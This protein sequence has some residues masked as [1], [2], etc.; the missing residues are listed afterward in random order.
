[1]MIRNDARNENRQY[2]NSV[3]AIEAVINGEMSI[4][5]ASHKYGI[6][7][8]TLRGRV[9]KTKDGDDGSDAKGWK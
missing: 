7:P 8:S 2:Q 9:K 1:M 3:L 6:P 4:S 5:E